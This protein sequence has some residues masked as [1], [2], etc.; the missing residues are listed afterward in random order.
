MTITESAR[1]RLQTL[2]KRVSLSDAGFRYRG[3][4]GTCRGSTPLL[5]PAESPDDGE[6]EVQC[7]GIRFFVPEDSR[8][9]FDVATLDFDNATLFRRGLYLTWAHGT[10]ACGCHC[11]N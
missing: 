10:V 4:V 11:T 9:M 8:A 2:L 7:A 5:L 6:Q 3:H 1:G